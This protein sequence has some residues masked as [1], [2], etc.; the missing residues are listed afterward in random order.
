MAIGSGVGRGGKLDCCS[1]AHSEGVGSNKNLTDDVRKILVDLG[2]QLSTITIADENKSEGVNEIED[3]LVAA[4][5]KVMSWEADQCMVW[6]SGPEEAAEYLKAVEETA[7]ARLEEEFRYLLFQNRQPFEPEHMSF[8]SNDEDVVDEGSIISLRMTQLRTPFRLIVLAEECSQ[9]YISVR[10]DALDECL[11]ILEMEKLSIEDVL[12]MEWAGLN[13]KIRRWVRAMKIFV[14]VYLASEK[15]L[16]D[17][18][19]GEVGSVS[20]ACFVEA[21]RASIFQLLEFW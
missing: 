20:S 5:D 6:D 2:T 19:F 15:W 3:R 9:A 8:R 1:T 16:S 4:Q 7:M 17:Q 13:S 10:K 14:R 21:S 18:V 11:S 12:K